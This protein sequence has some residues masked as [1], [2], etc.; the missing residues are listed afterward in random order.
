MKKTTLILGIMGISATV[1]A[2]DLIITPSKD[3][4][5]DT[6]SQSTNY[7]NEDTLRA[8][9]QSG[10]TRFSYIAFNLSGVTGLVASAKL[11][12]AAH[13]A[14]S[15]G[16]I[17]ELRYLKNGINENWSESTIT[18]ASFRPP[19]SAEVQIGNLPWSNGDPDGTWYSYDG[20]GSANL[21]NAINSD[22]NDI[23]TF[24]IRGNNSNM[25]VMNSENNGINIPKLEITYV[26]NNPAYLPPIRDAYI[27]QSSP[28][29]N[30]GTDNFMLARLYSGY[31]REAY[32]GFN[33][34][35]LKHRV[36]R[37]SLIMVADRDLTGGGIIQMH[38]LTDGVNEDWGE[39]TITWNNTPS[40][41]DISI[42]SL[43][44]SAGDTN[45]TVYRFRSQGLVDAINGD[46]NDSLTIHMKGNSSGM[47]Y[48]HSTDNTNNHP[49]LELTYAAPN[50]VV[51]TPADDSYIDRAAPTS[52]NGSAEYL[53]IKDYSTYTRRPHIA[54]DLS[55]IE[56]NYPGWFIQSAKLTFTA[57]GDQSGG[58]SVKISYLTDGSDES[59]DESTIT[60]NNKPAA[61][62]VPLGYVFNW[63][64]G[65]PAGTEYTYSDQ[66]LIDIIEDDSN[67]SL[68]IVLAANTSA[69][70]MLRLS[71]KEDGYGFAP[72]LEI[73]YAPTQG[74]FIIIQ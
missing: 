6:S 38:A 58:G 13:G 67:N 5:V 74:T 45:G 52:I 62:Y 65:D 25:L 27:L 41:S 71:S 1:M 10:Y 43:D 46:S 29:N 39:T 42:G 33:L 34:L 70:T 7:G 55:N 14:Q 31:T 63:N 53:N 56:T 44:W 49:Y 54:F 69:N 57:H 26:T 8:K 35:P 11:S 19:D 30:Y 36:I 15:G 64:D 20:S 4:Y 21:I 61:S 28:N 40:A 73:T 3:A 32:I 23:I 66:S 50:T 51:L 12:V 2:A 72:R 48:V 18:Y 60:W 22:T 47:F 16:G 59:W 17:A 9:S 24:V 68:T 37:A